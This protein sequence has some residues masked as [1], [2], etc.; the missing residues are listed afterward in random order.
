MQQYIYAV[1][2]YSLWHVVVMFTWVIL[3]TKGVY[4]TKTNKPWTCFTQE[5]AYCR[6]ARVPDFP[7]LRFSEGSRIFISFRAFISSFWVFTRADCS[8]LQ[9]HNCLFLKHATTTPKAG[10][11]SSERSA[12]TGCSDLYYF[13][14]SS[15]HT[16]TP[17][18]EPAK[19]N[20]RW[21]DVFFI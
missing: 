6:V 20:I 5:S 13:P 12:H 10:Q 18:Q 16:H 14:T 15:I 17:V 7:L 11:G 4:I 3:I 1:I 19:R 8:L 9:W 21:L 2:S